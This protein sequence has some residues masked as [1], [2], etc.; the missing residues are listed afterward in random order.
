MCEE[1]NW[2]KGRKRGVEI[3]SMDDHL[4]GKLALIKRTKFY[5]NLKKLKFVSFKSF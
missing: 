4:S 5:G 1:I 2:I 3:K